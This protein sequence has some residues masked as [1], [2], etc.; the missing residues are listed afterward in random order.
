VAVP[1]PAGQPTTARLSGKPHFVIGR[2][3]DGGRPAVVELEGLRR[4][5]AIFAGS[6]SGKT[7]LIRRLIEEC[8]LLGVSTIVLDPN[9]DL[10]RL[11]DAWPEPPA[12]WGP[13][14]AE[15]SA[16]YLAN[17]DVVVWT[18]RRASGR[19]LSFQPL[20]DFAGVLDSADEFDVAVDAAVATLAP[21]AG[22]DGRTAKAKQSR[23]VLTEALRYFG[24]SGGTDLRAFTG[25]LGALPDGMSQLE[26]AEKMAF[27][28]SQSLTAAM[29]IDPLFGGDG[30]A[31]DPGV[32]L[33]PPTGKRARVS[34]IS[35]VGLTSDEQ[36]QSFVNLLQLALFAWVKR[37]PAGDRPLGG[38][39]VMDEAQTLAP[40]GAM[41]ACT[42]STIALASQARKYGLGLVF[43]T[44]AP[45][46]LHNQIP[47]NAATQFFGLLNSPTQIAAAQELGR[48]K[49]SSLPDI[50][51]M[52]T[53]QFYA[54]IEGARFAKVQTPLCLTH[55]PQSPLTEEE[56][57][58][59]ARGE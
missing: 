40:S 5:A 41:T 34:V 51:R 59:R 38:L 18:P 42:K 3:S 10:A 54:G 31:V 16:E 2:E 48:A 50:G 35:L 14:D 19:P 24:R 58:R 1:G 44:Q 39:F 26:N 6:G 9:N 28:M 52:G 22:A 30:Q 45:K 55:H 36:R 32:L 49:G 4:H 57:I 37:N 20:P 12:L 43:A 27:E 17:T 47:G 29:V 33:T 13:G 11:G 23:A 25:L 15:R 53:G 8:A 56:V 46:G 7:V 21:R